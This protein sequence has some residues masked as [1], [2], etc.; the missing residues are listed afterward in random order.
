[1]WTRTRAGASQGTRGCCL[2]GTGQTPLQ[3][4]SASPGPGGSARS[5]CGEVR[6]K[7]QAAMS[8]PSPGGGPGP[9]VLRHR[10]RV[11]IKRSN[12]VSDSHSGTASAPSEQRFCPCS[13]H[14]QARVAAPGRARAHLGPLLSFES[15]SL[16]LGR[17]SFLSTQSSS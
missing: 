15:I 7:L 5:R 3:S 9:E 17:A 1:M 14:R 13:C 12:S 2:E 4:R 6:P 16:G 10:P 11:G 8:S